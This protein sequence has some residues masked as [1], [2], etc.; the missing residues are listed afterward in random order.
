MCSNPGDFVDESVD[1]DCPGV[2]GDEDVQ[3]SKEVN[4]D[5][6]EVGFG[7]A[8]DNTGF[9]AFAA[10][11]DVSRTGSR[12]VARGLAYGQLCSTSPMPRS[13]SCARGTAGELLVEEV[14]DD[15]P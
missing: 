10:N 2:D 13:R 1:D 6:P 3:E 12:F 14:A 5:M 4:S 8:V 11:D 7:F 9:L 15:S